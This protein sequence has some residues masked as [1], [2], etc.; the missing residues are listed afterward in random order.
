MLA[1]L[2]VVCTK[3][4]TRKLLCSWVVNPLG[5]GTLSLTP[6]VAERL[7]E[8]QPCLRCPGSLSCD[9]ESPGLPQ[10]DPPV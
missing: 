10:A 5:M 2:H 7:L 1:F 6:I 9:T 4:S 3:A 8:D